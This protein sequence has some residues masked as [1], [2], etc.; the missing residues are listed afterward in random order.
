VFHRLHF[1]L[2]QLILSS[3][4]QKIIVENEIQELRAKINNHL[5]K[6]QE[7]LMK[8]L[9]EVE[10]NVTDETHDLMVVIV[11]IP[12]SILYDSVV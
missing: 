9:T 10:Q 12:A 1:V 2:L 6:L 7:D 11:L 4:E 8:V 5:D 3:R